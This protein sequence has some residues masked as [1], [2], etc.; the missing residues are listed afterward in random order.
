MIGFGSPRLVGHEWKRN[1][2]APLRPGKHV[3]NETLSSIGTHRVP[4]AGGVAADANVAATRPGQSEL[5]HTPRLV[6]DWT[7]RHSCDGQAA[8]PGID[9]AGDDVAPR[10]VRRRVH[11]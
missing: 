7:D 9:V 8:V 3:G 6:F 5:V 11:G 1:R 10:V 2:H 4:L